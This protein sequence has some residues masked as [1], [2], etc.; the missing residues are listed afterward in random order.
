M[1]LKEI[2]RLLAAFLTVLA[3]WLLAAS[4]VN[5]YLFPSPLQ[6]ADPFLEM[7]MKPSTWFHVAATFNRVLLGVAL[8]SLLGLVLGIAPRYSSTASFVVESVIQPVLESVPALCWALIFAALFGLSG[9]APVFVVAAAII[10]FFT[11]NLWEGVKELD[12]SLVEMAYA[13]T[14]NKL[15]VF[16]A[17]ILPMLYPYLF[18][19]LRTSFEVAWKVVVLGEVFGAVNGIGYMLWLSFS[20]YSIDRM[21]AWVLFCAA[22]IAFFEYV[23]FNLIDKRLIRRWRR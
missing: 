2:A 11:I 7:I 9:T 21:F 16:K 8:G 15:R 17:V 20:S 19:A 1:N 14:R 13:Y 18:A 6:V 23:V 22:I 12:E 10:P 4:L 3:V 5:S